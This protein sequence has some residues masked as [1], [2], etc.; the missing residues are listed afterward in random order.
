MDDRRTQPVVG[1][2]E[3]QRQQQVFDLL[4]EVGELDAGEREAR[5]AEAPTDVA[6][7][8]RSLLDEYDE[9]SEGE[10]LPTHRPAGPNLGD[11]ALI[12]LDSTW[13][14]GTRI[15]DYNIVSTL[16]TGGMGQVYLAEPR[17]HGPRVAIKRLALDLRS[18]PQ[19]RKRFEIEQQ[20]ME[21]L[22][23]PNVGRI[24]GSGTGPD[25]GPYLVMEWIEGKRITAYCDH[26]RLTI[27]ERIGLFVDLCCGVAHAHQQHLL[28]RDIKPAN[29][30]VTEVDGHPVPKLIDFG[31]AKD[32]DVTGTLGLTGSH[33]IGTP[34]YMSPEALDGER[35]VDT[36]SDV[37][38]LGVLLHEL[39]VD[40]VPWGEDL[41]S[42]LAHL[43]GR[44][45]A[46]NPSELLAKMPVSVLSDIAAFRGTQGRELIATL[47][48][49]LDRIV[50]Q[51]LASDVEERTPSAE[52]LISQLEAT[53]LV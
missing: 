22:D 42:F 21:R 3:I 10:F 25:G 33:A 50:L 41:S 9:E 40:R 34:T 44:H 48:G 8:V 32:L 51:A 11:G 30:L 45:Q 37:F 53:A 38:S 39:L 24:L 16:G 28:H 29:V 52:T 46:E 23:H 31:I 27:A 17:G 36:R 47:R 2:E 20:V 43:N 14:A 26:H 5:L 1:R 35:K 12:G 4:M 15:G 7:E 13:E 18:L 49:D 6:V 19:L